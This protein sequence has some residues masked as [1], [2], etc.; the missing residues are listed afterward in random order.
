MAL[1][2]FLSHLL[3]DRSKGDDLPDIPQLLREQG[4]TELA[5]RVDAHRRPSLLLEPAPPGEGLRVG[6]SR[7]GGAP[8]LPPGFK[9]PEHHG[10]PLDFLAQ[11]NLREVPAA[12]GPSP[13]P[14]TGFL[15]F[16]YDTHN[17]PSG[18]QAADADGWR[19]CYADV[20]ADVLYADP[21]PAAADGDRFPVLPLVPEWRDS[22][23][24]ELDF[25]R[26]G[27]ELTPA[28]ESSLRAQEIGTS[29]DLILHRMLGYADASM[30]EVELDCQLASAGVAVPDEP[31]PDAPRLA[32]LL[33]GREDWMLLLQ[34]DS[35]ERA[36]MDW[37]EA[38]R[39]FFCLRREDLAAR[40][41][42]NAWCILQAY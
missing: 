36:G 7:L 2:D 8:D 31:D 27:I 14:A 3:P 39:L 30:R 9:W 23:P 20:A 26:L 10:R 18:L 5:E 28:E 21:I 22:W 15:W 12:D 25:H 24:G 13:L 17:N 16:F 11:I 32:P 33:E 29:E 4:L 1:L 42:E 38:G 6:A 34:L 37:G 41:F 19:V 35:D 40:R